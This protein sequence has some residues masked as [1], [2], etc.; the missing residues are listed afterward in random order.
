ME[1]GEDGARSP[2]VRDRAEPF[3]HPALLYRSEQEYAQGTLPF[4]SEGL[5]AGLPVAVAAP[6][7][8]LALL[9]AEL[10]P[11]AHEVR[12]IDMTQAGRNPGRIIPAVLR[13]FAD[14]HPGRPVRI[15]GEPIWYGRTPIEY[16]AC[17]QHEALI[18]TAFHGR[19]ATILCPYD[20][21][22]LSDDVIADAHA[23]HPVVISDG[24]PG[25]SHAYDPERVLARYNETL[26]YPP[27]AATVRFAAGLLPAARDFALREARERGMAPPRLQDL[28]LV[29]A[30]LTTNSVV[31]GGGSGTLRIW[32]ESEQ[33]V[34]EVR[35]EGHLTDPLAGRLP[36]R[37]DQLGGRGLLLVHFL[38]DLVRVHTAASGT[39]VRSYLARR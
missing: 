36:V 39:T 7:S 24:R 30:E 4:V 1:Q 34:C 21:R 9:K 2:F 28:N 31:H 20:A 32:A 27:G 23:T 29:V 3:A 19:D 15:I 16:P 6:P 26:P 14:A 11:V 5:A 8:R 10:G 37:P 18:N 38:S 17:A 25:V 35:D 33:I 22:T 13:S 12:W